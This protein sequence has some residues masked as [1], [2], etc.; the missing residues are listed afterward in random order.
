LRQRSRLT[1]A[2]RAGLTTGIVLVESS[3]DL[4]LI[5]W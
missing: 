1:R 5:W 4:M 3:L 2:G